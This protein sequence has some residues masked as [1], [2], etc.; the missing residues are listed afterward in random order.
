M[1]TGLKATTNS[2]FVQTHTHSASKKPQTNQPDNP[3]LNDLL[4]YPLLLA[5]A[6]SR[7]LGVF[8]SILPAWLKGAALDPSHASSL[9]ICWFNSLIKSTLN[10]CRHYMSK[11][12][13]ACF[14]LFLLP[15]FTS[16]LRQTQRGSQKHT[17]QPKSHS[18]P[19]VLPMLTGS[20][21][22][23]VP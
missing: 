6:H 16:Y 21:P 7:D 17:N 3:C 12:L 18:D 9:E 22:S 10:H 11:L 14:C 20:G 19:S 8:P 5:A 1:V 13:S 4:A 2:R 23:E 15:R